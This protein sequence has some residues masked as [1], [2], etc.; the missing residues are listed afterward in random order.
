MRLWLERTL[1]SHNFLYYLFHNCISYL[2]WKRVHW[3]LNTLLDPIHTGTDNT[4]SAA[5]MRNTK[6]P[7]ECEPPKVIVYD[8][9]VSVDVLITNSKEGSVLSDVYKCMQ[10]E[11]TFT[12]VIH[13]NLYKT[14]EYQCTPDDKVESS[15]TD[16]V[17]SRDGTSV[18]F[19]EYEHMTQKGRVVIS[20]E[21]SAK[22]EEDIG[23]GL[24]LHYD[25]EANASVVVYKD[26]DDPSVSSHGV[27]VVAPNFIRAQ[28]KLDT[29]VLSMNRSGYTK[30]KPDDNGDICNIHVKGSMIIDRYI[31]LNKCMGEPLGGW[32]FG[33]HSGEWF[34]PPKEMVIPE[35]QTEL[36]I[37]ERGDLVISRGNAS[38][39]VRSD[40]GVV[41]AGVVAVLQMPVYFSQLGDKHDSMTVVVFQ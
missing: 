30:I 4:R 5:T 35:K 10:I 37:V 12:N 7:Q 3:K 9:S 16:L 38:V 28:T 2:Q 19:G 31:R 17:I 13:A 6:A 11:G 29:P 33:Q 24:G 18:R 20:R 22:F 25:I 32:F 14:E 21:A 36:G 1:F 8:G 26:K 39:L 15:S 40:G 41:A 23:D 34:Q 27:L